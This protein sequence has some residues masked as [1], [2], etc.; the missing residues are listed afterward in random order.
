MELA[1]EIVPTDVDIFEDEA[2]P[3][4]RVRGVNLQD[5]A[6]ANMYRVRLDEW[7]LDENPTSD[8]ESS[9]EEFE[10]DDVESFDMDMPPCNCAFLNE[11]F[12]V[13]GGDDGP[14]QLEQFCGKC[15]S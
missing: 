2:Y 1:T 5:F 10:E 12:P 7:Q 4:V 9:S 3:A 13:G 8:A 14:P 6:F 11:N 15:G